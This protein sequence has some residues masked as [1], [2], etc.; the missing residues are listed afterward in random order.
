MSRSRAGSSPR[1]FSKATGGTTA[2]RD[3]DKD[4]VEKIRKS[5]GADSGFPIPLEYQTFYLP[6]GNDSVEVSIPDILLIQKDPSKE[7]T[8]AEMEAALEY[9]AAYRY[10]FLRAAETAL[11]KLERARLA[12]KIW[13]AE[14][15]H[16]AEMEIKRIR[17][18]EIKTKIR[19]EIGQITAAL[20]EDWILRQTESGAK[21]SYIEQQENI[22][23]LEGGYTIL[24]GL[25]DTCQDRAWHLKAILERR[26]LLLSR[27]S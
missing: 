1:D 21:H 13:Y 18:E 23:S 26:T 25:V 9:S 5:S 7:Y 22:R 4:R 8:E 17:R 14:Q 24:K 27:P 11:A 12:F 2:R 16:L 20:V 3:A 15:A 19:K 6:V 10:T